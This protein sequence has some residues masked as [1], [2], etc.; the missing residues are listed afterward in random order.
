[1]IKKK[2][3]FVRHAK[4]SWKHNVSDMDRPLKQRGRD[5]ASIISQEFKKLKTS[6][7]F[8]YSSPANRALSTC[9]IFQKYLGFPESM[10]NITENLYDFSGE[11]ALEFIRSIDNE[12]NTV[13]LF[14][15][16]YAFTSLINILGDRII[17]NLPTSGLVIIDF[18][19]TSWEHVKFG[20]TK[21][22]MFPKDYRL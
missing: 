21:T 3:M 2:I 9:K 12:L 7:D 17:D 8:I 4:S 6:I 18:N 20:Q 13:M 14:G 19:V 15:H 5:D 22:I 10:L 11:R 16:N 1:M